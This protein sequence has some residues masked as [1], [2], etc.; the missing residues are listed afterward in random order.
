MGWSDLGANQM[1][2][3]RVLRANGVN[4]S[5]I[6]IEQSNRDKKQY[7]VDNIPKRTVATLSKAVRDSV[8]TFGN[9]PPIDRGT[10]GWSP[11]LRRLANST[12]DI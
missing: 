7:I 9:I 5:Q 2:Q 12:F 4:V 1:A 10:S 3:V 6:H 8:E 11:L